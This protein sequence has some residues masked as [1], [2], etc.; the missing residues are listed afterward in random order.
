LD[1][2]RVW[3]ECEEEEVECEVCQN[4]RQV[5]MQETMVM[6]HGEEEEQ[7]EV[8]SE[9]ERDE[10]VEELKVVQLK[11]QVMADEHMTATKEV[12]EEAERLWRYLE[13][14]CGMCSLC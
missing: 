11:Q 12:A 8:S 7:E 1:G 14:I 10:D 13:N 3:I 6:K 5:G 4:G 9:E 2:Q